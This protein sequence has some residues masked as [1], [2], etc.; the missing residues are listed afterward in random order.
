LSDTTA[1]RVYNI[2]ESPSYSELEWGRRVAAITDWHGDF[3]ILPL[4][5]MPVHLRSPANFDQHWTADTTRIRSELGFTERV[6]VDTAIRRTIAWERANPPAV[7]LAPID[8]DAEDA[9]IA[10]I[11][12]GG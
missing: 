3:V 2:A 6:D 10:S 12:P 8:Y 1:G 5:R 4:E 7:P 11:T 9:A